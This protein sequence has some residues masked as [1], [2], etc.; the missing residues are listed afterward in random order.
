MFEPLPEAETVSEEVE[1]ESSN[2]FMCF[3]NDDFDICYGD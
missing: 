1:E 3:D 2:S